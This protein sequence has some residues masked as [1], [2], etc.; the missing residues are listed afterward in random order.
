MSHDGE[1]Q[2][3]GINREVNIWID[4]QTC[5]TVRNY[6][7]IAPLLTALASLW[8]DVPEVNTPNTLN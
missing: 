5:Q 8:R 4:R 2:Q 7:R 3:C 6:L 1:T